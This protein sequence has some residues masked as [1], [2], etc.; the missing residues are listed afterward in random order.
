M[1]VDVV[2]PV[3]NEEESISKVIGDIPKA[4][5]RE[6]VVVNNNSTDRTAENAKEAGATVVNQ[7]IQGYGAACLK[8][9]EYIAAKKDAPDILAFV[10][11]DYSD[12][13]SQMTD[14]VAPIKSKG[15]DLV[16]GSRALGKRQRGSM[17]IPQVVGNKIASILLKLFYG[18][19]FTDLGPFRAMKYDSLK[20]LEMSDQN[21]GWTVEM[22]LKVAKAKMSYVEVP[23]DY[24]KRI[25]K[26]KISGT[27]KGAVMA[28]VI[29]IKT[30]FK[31]R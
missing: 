30:I 24:R 21:F 25:G 12:Y 9:L 22:Q 2:I 14:V 7:T 1:I 6:I 17:T 29:I 16:I 13:P 20:K 28:G 26:S 23:V 4:L 5:V 10:D 27:I 11:G 8:G 31:Y 18:A 15:V 19:K 3:Y